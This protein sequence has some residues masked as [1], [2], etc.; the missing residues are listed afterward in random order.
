[1]G[2]HRLFLAASAWLLVVL[3]AACGTSG[4][5][6]PVGATAREYAFQG[7]PA[8]LPA[9]QTSFT[10]DNQGGEVHELH[11]FKLDDGVGTVA[12]LLGMSQD[13]A[14]DKLESVG[15]AMANPGDEES[16]DASLSAG[17][18]AAVCLIPVGT[19]PSG[20]HAGHD[21]EDMVFDPN[22]DTHFK[23]GMYSEFT[24]G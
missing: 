12:E 10:V 8:T 22:A 1:M 4:G 17:R 14:A 13:E 23:R 19:K 6:N 21:M 20:G 3:P 24:V 18:Y 5:G 9:G 7:I 11:L 16:F 15:S 2:K